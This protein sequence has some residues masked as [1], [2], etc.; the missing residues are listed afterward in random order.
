[1]NFKTQKA[2]NLLSKDFKIAIQS[3]K[4]ILDNA[5]ITS[6]QDLCENSEFIFDFIKEKI[7][8]NFL[9]ATDENNYLNL[10]K[11]SNIYCEDFGDF[12]IKGLVKF[13]SEDLTDEILEVLENGTNEQRAC[14]VKYFNHIKD[15][16]V[17][18]Y[19]KDFT[20]SDY[21]P[22]NYNC[23]KVLYNF[24]DYEKYNEAI[25]VLQ[26]S[27]DDF[28]KIKA[29]NFLSAFGDKNAIEYLYN[30]MLNSPFSSEVALAI[31]EL[32]SLNN[33]ED[34]KALNI[35][36]NI[37]NSYPEFLSL[38]TIIAYNIYSYLK[39]ILNTELN[40]EKYYIL[41]KTKIKFN[42]FVKEDIYTFDLDK[43]TKEEVKKINDLINK[44]YE[45]WENNLPINENISYIEDVLDTIIEENLEQYREEIKNL[46]NKTENE[47]IICKCAQA[48]NNF[49][50]EIN[51]DILNKIKNQNIEAIIAG[52]NSHKA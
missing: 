35:Y 22:L 23:A 15:P 4:E 10:I 8:N 2:K 25:E 9:K 37:L 7:N 17:L 11:L 52:L 49:N 27:Q 24:N 5:D 41:Y 28:G 38:D 20:Y 31:L 1:M 30:F 18:D 47:I 21:E 29:V 45:N 42:L 39:K 19:L 32:D 16:L 50:A 46:M 13:A 26:K 33:I 3:A 40:E 48:L 36:N 44:H 51:P 34:N 43:E 6:F 12:I 14:L